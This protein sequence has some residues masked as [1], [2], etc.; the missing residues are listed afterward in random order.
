MTNIAVGVLIPERIEGENNEILGIWILNNNYYYYQAELTA[1]GVAEGVYDNNNNL[2]D[3]YE[4]TYEDLEN[5]TIGIA[6]LSFT[7]TS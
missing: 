1:E 5:A 3:D 6:S 7:A 4:I 2:I